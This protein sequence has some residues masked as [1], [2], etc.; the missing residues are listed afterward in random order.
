MVSIKIYSRPPIQ[1]LEFEP[2]VLTKIHWGSEFQIWASNL[3]PLWTEFENFFQP[4]WWNPVP[5]RVNLE[6]SEGLNFPISFNHGEEITY[7]LE[8]L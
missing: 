2:L 3:K 5:F 4:W 8:L 1:G 6:H 7:L